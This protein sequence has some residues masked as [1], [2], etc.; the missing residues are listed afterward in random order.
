MARHL[1]IDF[2]DCRHH[3]MNRGARRQ[4]IFLDESFCSAF[5]ELVQQAIERYQIRVHGFC[6]MPNHYHLMVQSVRGNLSAAMKHVG[7]GYSQVV[8][9]KMGWDGSVF[10]GRFKN[11]VVSS[12][13]HW[14]YLLAYLHLNPVRGRLVLKPEQAIWTSHKAYLGSAPHQNWVTTT[15]LVEYLGDA[16]GYAAFIKEVK[17]G[18]RPEP[19]G[20]GSVL[21]GGHER[22]SDQLIKQES[23]SGPNEIEELLDW[24][25]TTTGTNRESLGTTQRGHQGNPSRALAVWL[26]AHNAGISNV[27]VGEVLGMSGNAVTKI[28]TKL[29]KAPRSYFGGRVA[30]WLE[31]FAQLKGQ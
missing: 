13:E 1:R 8:N 11:Q 2:P 7:E 22:N 26:L 3:V 25:C 19:S 10:R 14:L 6:L 16:A 30:E 24:V 5:V 12:D 27:E 29:R 15:E 18:S 17:E 31:A 23:I 28:L 21:F 4:P 9:K 20:F